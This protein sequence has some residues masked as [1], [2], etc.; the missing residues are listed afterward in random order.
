MATKT[1]IFKILTLS[2]SLLISIIFS[3]CTSHDN[4]IFIRDPGPM[5]LSDEREERMWNN[6]SERSPFA[7]LQ[8]EVCSGKKEGDICE[9]T[10]LRGEITGKCSTNEDQLICLPDVDLNQS[11]LPVGDFGPRRP[12]DLPG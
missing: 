7:E 12:V 6:T 5:N 4:D 8:L 10:T 1:E 2:M 3:G 9:F 11:A